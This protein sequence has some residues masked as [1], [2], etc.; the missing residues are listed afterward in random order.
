MYNLMFIMEKYRV[1]NPIDYGL[2]KR[3]NIVQISDG[4]LGIMKN[5]DLELL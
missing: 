5:V 2:G 4:H 3:V 1:L